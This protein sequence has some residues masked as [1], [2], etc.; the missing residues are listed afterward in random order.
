MCGGLGLGFWFGFCFGLG[1]A[2]WSLPLAEPPSP[3]GWLTQSDAKRPGQSSATPV[4]DGG[5]GDGE[6]GG[7]GGY[8]RRFAPRLGDGLRGVV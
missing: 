5:G 8:G 1:F 3:V 4:A 7:G 2:C 6:G